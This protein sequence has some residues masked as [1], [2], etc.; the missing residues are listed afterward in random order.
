M[1]LY[2]IH[3]ELPNGTQRR[4]AVRADDWEAAVTI[5]RREFPG[6]QVSHDTIPSPN[7]TPVAAASRA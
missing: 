6:A 1:T 2:P 5:A 4:G 3:L 7:V